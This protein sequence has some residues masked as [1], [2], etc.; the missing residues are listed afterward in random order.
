MEMVF[1]MVAG[2]VLTT[3]VLGQ[4][5]SSTSFE[6]TV[7]TSQWGTN[8]IAIADQYLEKASSPS[9]SFDQGV[10]NQLIDP[11]ATDATAKL[12]LLSS[13]LGRESGE[14][15][16]NQFNDID[17]YN[18]FVTVVKEPFG[19]DTTRMVS[20]AVYCRVSYY[21]P[22][23]GAPCASPTWHKQISVTVRDTVEGSTKR[24]LASISQL[25]N[26]AQLTKSRVVSF[27]RFL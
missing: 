4:A 24:V 2:M 9:L 3:I 10:I 15:T 18:N 25:G 7:T 12:S 22:V 19:L 1:I 17:D 27:W 5:D 11:T 23:T 26:P 6:D 21:N 13:T 8:A 14:V 20:F 16:E